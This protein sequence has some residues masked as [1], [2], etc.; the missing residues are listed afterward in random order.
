MIRG[1]GLISDQEA[2]DY[3]LGA[4]NLGKRLG[5]TRDK[6][7]NEDHGILW[8]HQAWRTGLADVRRS[9]RPTVSF[10]CTVANCEY[11]FY[12]HFYQ[13]DLQ[14][15]QQ[16][17]KKW[18]FVLHRTGKAVA[19]GCSYRAGSPNGS[20]RPLCSMFLLFVVEVDVKVEEPGKDSVHNNAFCTQETLLK[21]ESHAMR[22]CN[23]LSARHWIVCVLDHSCSYVRRLTC[24]AIGED[25]IYASGMFERK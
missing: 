16:Q 24:D 2:L 1:C 7:V 15:K 9:R 14:E 22:D 4:S 8:K 17:Y 19:G 12:W 10:I 23:P 11:G 6:I 21:S 20:C 13:E 5:E 18:K 3:D 25:W